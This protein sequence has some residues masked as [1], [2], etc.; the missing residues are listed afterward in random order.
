MFGNAH[1]SSHYFE[2]YID[3]K[4]VAV[5]EIVKLTESK[6]IYLGTFKSAASM[7]RVGPSWMLHGG[8]RK[9]PLTSPC[10]IAYD[11]VLQSRNIRGGS[12]LQI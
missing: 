12:S 6:V 8:C 2:I 7:R 3:D 10:L 9:T 11:A 5:Y 1:V 4:I